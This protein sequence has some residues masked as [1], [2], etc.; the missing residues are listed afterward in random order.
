MIVVRKKPLSV[1]KG[2]VRG[3][4][5]VKMSC[6][7]PRPERR[8]SVCNH[9]LQSRSRRQQQAPSAAI[10]STQHCW[11]FYCSVWTSAI[12]HPAS[13]NGNHSPPRCGNSEHRQPGY[14]ATLSHWYC[15]AAPGR[16]RLRRMAEEQH[17]VTRSSA[18]PN[19]CN[20][21]RLTTFHGIS[22]RGAVNGI[23]RVASV[24]KV[25][26][27]NSSEPD[28]C[29]YHRKV[30]VAKVLA[31]RAGVLMAKGR[32]ASSSYYSGDDPHRCR[33]EFRCLPSCPRQFGAVVPRDFAARRTVS[34]LQRRADNRQS[35]SG[36]D[37]SKRA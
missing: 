34:R 32:C 6:Y 14:R 28:F 5:V 21:V 36:T 7:R 11:S 10:F 37:G 24:G 27:I 22:P 12:Q 3:Y 20:I 26:I 25:F 2:G 9:R 8:N 17:A 1:V 18:L 23:R 13:S 15:A 30:V 16:I 29:G 35:T 33:C 31:A 19:T 4:V